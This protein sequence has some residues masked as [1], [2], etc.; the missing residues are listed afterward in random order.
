MEAKKEEKLEAEET[1]EKTSPFEW[2]KDVLIAIVIAIVIMQFIKPTLVKERSMQPNFVENDYVFVSRQSYKLFGGDPERGDVIVL[3]SSL[4]DGD[5]NDKLLIKRVIGL[6][7][8]SITV[9]DGDV[10]INGEELSDDYTKDQMTNGEIID[11]KIPEDSYFCMGDNRE[12]S[13]DS[14]DPR[15]GFIKKEQI[16]GKVVLRLYPFNKFGT[17][18]NPYDD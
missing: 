6:P 14:R 11:L 5:G 2:V 3:H 16:V 10:Y 9:S 7:G 12:L 1:Q 8:E 4:K 18:Y 17:I 15:V 13:M